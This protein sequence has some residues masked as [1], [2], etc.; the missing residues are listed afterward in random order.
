MLPG[1]D[2]TEEVGFELTRDNWMLPGVCGAPG[3]QQASLPLTVSGE[4]M[5]SL[6]PNAFSVMDSGPSGRT[7][8]FVDENHSSG[9]DTREMTL[10]LQAL[11][12]TLLDRSNFPST[13]LGRSSA[14]EL[15][16]KVYEMRA[17]LAP[18]NQANTGTIPKP[19]KRPTVSENSCS[20]SYVY[21]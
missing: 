8:P 13:Y 21:V 2:F 15:V 20:L 1:Q 9:D 4:T 6:T 12:G 14:T 7:S 11:R 17:E 19:R 16:R 5:D 18:D 3:L 10:K